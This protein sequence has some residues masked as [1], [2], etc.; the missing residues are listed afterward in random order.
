MRISN[1]VGV[2]SV[3]LVLMMATLGCGQRESTGV[4]EVKESGAAPTQPSATPQASSPQNTAPL[5]AI[6]QM[7][8]EER[9]GFKSGDKANPHA[10][11]DTGMPPGHPKIEQA[12]LD[13]TAPPGWEKQPDRG[14]RVVTYKSKDGAECYVSL[15][16]G[17]AGGVEGNITR[18]RGQMGQPPLSAEEIAAL[19]KVKLLGTDAPMVEIHGQFTGMSGVP[20]PGQCLYGAIGAMGDQSLFIKMVGAD[21]S[22]AAEKSNFIAFC[23]SLNKKA[24]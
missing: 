17:A 1:R 23:Q 14:M 20:T 21:A 16:A 19:P 24:S 10:G 15:L 9:M 3:V 13:W 8:A 22:M 4:I 5:T 12:P 11:M 6:P 7:S 2:I 18:W